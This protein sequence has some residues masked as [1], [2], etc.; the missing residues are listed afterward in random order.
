VVD[1]SAHVTV[2]VHHVSGGPDEVGVTV[3]VHLSNTWFSQARG[4]VAV[5]GVRVV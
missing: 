3:L 1:A 5:G 4:P 2:A